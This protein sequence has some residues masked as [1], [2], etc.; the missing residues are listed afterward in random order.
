MPMSR[1]CQENTT[2]TCLHGIVQGNAAVHFAAEHG[3]VNLM[4]ELMCHGALV[5][6]VDVKVSSSMHGRTLPFG[7]QTS[8]TNCH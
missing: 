7:M 6:L 2:I 5:E 8:T 4:A 3:D 1:Y